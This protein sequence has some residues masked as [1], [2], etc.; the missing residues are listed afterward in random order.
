MKRKSD[1]CPWIEWLQKQIHNRMGRHIASLHADNEF[2]NKEVWEICKQYR[3]MMSPSAP[4]DHD[5]GGLREQMNLTYYNCVR[6]MLQVTVLLRN[7]WGLALKCLTAM[8]NLSP[9]ARLKNECKVPY[10]LAYGKPAY[11]SRLCAF[12][13][14]CYAHVPSEVQASK[15][16][17]R[18]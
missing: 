1:A 4:Y 9:S 12:G 5:A 18:G 7:R 11:Y 2:D 16:G 3:T 17:P 8:R 15:L 14:R 10:E 6:A 13:E